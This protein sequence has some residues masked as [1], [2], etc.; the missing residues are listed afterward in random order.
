MLLWYARVHK[1][2]YTVAAE[3]CTSRTMDVYPIHDYHDMFDKHPNDEDMLDYKQKNSLVLQKFKRV[4]LPEKK[5]SCEFVP[6]CIWKEPTC[7][8][9]LKNWYIAMA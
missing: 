6:T 8:A 5:S 3:W 1:T 9:T 4:E 7:N 2:R